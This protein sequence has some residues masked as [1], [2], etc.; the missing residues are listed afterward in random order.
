M[1]RE[2]DAWAI[3]NAAGYV[4]VDDAEHEPE[5]CR[6]L[7]VTV[8]EVQADACARHGIP[9]VAF[10]SDL[11]F[12]GTKRTPYTEFDPVS[13]LG[14]YGRT[15]AECETR[16]LAELPSALVVRTAAFFGPWDEWNFITRTLASLRLGVPV[17]AADDLVVSPTYVPHLV[18]SALDLLIDGERGI[19]HLANAGETTWAELAR[20]AARGADLDA[21]LV[22]GCPHTR[23]GL[24]ARRPAY[25]ALGSERA[26]I[27]PSL[28]TA[29]AAYLNEQPWRRGLRDD[30]ALAMSSQD[31]AD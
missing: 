1:I 5:H 15:K 23:L 29:L 21:S 3:V 11:V 31:A 9:L 10:S 2:T 17:N 25:A 28:D 27:M 24:I 20:M 13:P 18:H 4:R 14:V 22:R 26:Q 12:D 7:N 8:A 30:D 16:V 6:W 19:W